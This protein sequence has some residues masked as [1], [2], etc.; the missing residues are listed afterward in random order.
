[1]KRSG[2]ISVLYLYFLVFLYLVIF[3][4]LFTD[5]ISILN[6]WDEFIAFLAVPL[7]LVKGRKNRI[8]TKENRYEPYIFLM[9]ICGLIG[10]C[11]YSYQPLF[12]AIIPDIIVCVKFWLSIY[13]GTVLLGNIDIKKYGKKIGFQVKSIIFI[14]VL[15]FF[16]DKLFNIF[17]GDIRY[18]LKSTWLFYGIHS[19]FAGI[20]AVLLSLL[21][22]VRREIKNY[23]KF[24]IILLILMASTLRSKSFAGILI[25]ILIYFVIYKNKKIDF[26]SVI[27]CAVLCFLIGWSQ[28]QVYFL[29]TE[30]R[31][32]AVLLKTS[33][34]IMKDYFPFGTG[35]ATFASHFSG[36]VYSPIY[37]MYGI[38]NV[39]GLAEGHTTY[40]SDSFWP[41]I[42]A[43]FGLIGTICFVIAL[44][45]LFKK[46]QD[47]REI[48]IYYYISAL[49][50]FLYLCV[51]S[52]AESAF[53]H[54]LSVPYGIILGICFAQIKKID[55]GSKK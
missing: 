43:Q 30:E 34:E 48:D 54:T 12:K 2:K 25:F 47:L 7:W 8:N 33:L 40:V 5:K 19:Y 21:T 4:D 20:C 51:I 35:F 1:M 28:I 36:S 44:V 14:F 41:M 29:S 16:L 15:L 45:Q 31:A 26:K 55:E 32:R 38:S 39:Y 27:I 49:F 24:A 17:Y 42:F 50:V 23:W 52:V 6:Y 46:I 10:T 11:A 9:I 53:V 13:V 18:G 3:V 37:G 22:L